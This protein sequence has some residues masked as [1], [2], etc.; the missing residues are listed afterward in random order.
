MPISEA[1]V[2]A[3]TDHLRATIERENATFFETTTAIACAHFAARDVDIA[4]V[5][6]GLGGRLDSTNVIDEKE[7][8]VFTPIGL[9]HTAILGNTEDRGLAWF[10]G[11][12]ADR[13]GCDTEAR[14]QTIRT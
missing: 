14:G 6:V 3:W 8:C 5:E 9:E 13:V 11:H 4:V 1:A 2:A 7:V 12:L 10:V